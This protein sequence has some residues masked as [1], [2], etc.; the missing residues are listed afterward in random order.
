[1]DRVRRL[2]TET[3]AYEPLEASAEDGDHDDSP[4]SSR[5][6][7]LEYSIFFLLGVA[8][9]WAWNMFLAAA[10]YFHDRFESSEWFA[11]H[12]QSSILSVSTVTNLVAAYI[13][14]R[15][16]K[17]VSYPGRITLSLLINC[18]IFTLLAFSTIVMKDVSVGGYF[19]FLMIMVFGASFATG[20]NQNG[21][22]AYVAGFGREEY[23][24]AIMS[25]QG[26]AG[27]LPCIAQ[28]LSVL[29]VSR[30]PG[31]NGSPQSSSKSAFTYFLTATVVS[32]LTLLAFL[33]LLRRRPSA[34]SKALV[35]DD[36]GEDDQVDQKSVSLWMLFKKLRY[37][38]VSVFLCFTVT[39]MF[40][41]VFTT[42]IMSVNDLTKSRMYDPSVFIPLGFLF[43][44]IGDLGGRMLVAIPRFSLAHRPWIAFVFSI[45][46]LG[47][48]PLYLL[49][50]IHGRGA[51]VQSDFFYLCIVQL[52]FG[53]TNG[54]LASSC[55]MGASIWVSEDEREAAGGFM[56]M[57]LV[58]GL[59][60]G[61][62]LSFLVAS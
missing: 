10:P 33:H 25:G 11:T 34:Q 49:C 23:M 15:M 5:F 58:G 18:A 16:Q 3:S 37:L 44:N 47:F 38:S 14:A 7:R 31:Q 40:F 17:N 12:Y 54:Y 21:V 4:R 52:L 13:L 2:L 36:D 56:G 26:V 62:L 19:A 61:S 1:M 39:M 27:V 41:P 43:W 32:I 50:N 48:A 28:I 60:A 9:L 29:V 20:L 59:T 53:A 8:M 55:M 57:M 22:F 30:K 6:S 42:E 51:V 24:Q 45:A 35:E 46:R